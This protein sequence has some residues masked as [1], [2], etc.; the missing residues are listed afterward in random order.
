[1]VP[2]LAISQMR[3]I[4]TEAIGGDLDTGYSYM[5]K[6]GDALLQAARQMAPSPSGGDIAIVCGKG[7]N[8]G[9][10][11]VVARLLREAG[12]G[13]MCFSL[14]DPTDLKG[15][16][17]KAFD[18]YAQ[19]SGNYLVLDDAADCEGFA[20]YALVVDAVLG[21]GIKGE[22]HGLC[23]DVIA[24]MNRSDKPILAVDTPSG[25]DNDTGGVGESCVRARTTV[26]MGLPKL[27]A[28]QHPGRACVGT[29]VV[30]DL[31]YPDAIVNRHVQDV[32]VPTLDD[33]AALLPPRR[34]AGSKFD[35]GVTLLVSG[36]R[37]MAGSA[38]LASEAALRTGCGMVRCACPRSVADVLA[39]KV[40]ETVIV[41]LEET[42]SGSLSYQ[43]FDRIVEVAAKAQAVCIGP[44]LSHAP[45]TVRLV[46][47]L[48]A[49]LK[50]PMV[51]DA[52][53]LNAFKGR[54]ED[55]AR[56]KADTVITPH[57]GE[58]ER[59]FG[60]LPVKPQEIVGALKEKARELGL[61]ILLKGSP[62]M[63]AEP[64]GMVFVA[65]Y[66]TSALAKAG[67]GDVLS[68]IIVSLMAQGCSVVDAAILGAYLHG[69]AGERASRRLTEY[70][71][72]ARDVIGEV[73]RAIRGL[74]GSVRQQ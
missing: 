57:L 16:A 66:G 17:R 33:L 34:P 61:T 68:G 47:S 2:I 65:P 62:T 69:T 19:A 58:W 4:D 74:L 48:V 1:M 35:H 54:A 21:T 73:P 46:R 3:A 13:V 23:A 40:T 24:A 51:L 27:G 41:P 63:V 36:S 56:R 70:G 64:G 31:G 26:T 15:E 37:G 59:L 28:F 7:N 8:G 44:G 42:T 39:V 25:M 18:A 60:A 14:C 29:L 55:L 11:Y 50:A 22:P 12:Y 38:A 10:G 53:G 43:A 52:D 30:A 20:R 32:F 67:T 71:V 5:L 49:T 45:S 6:A 72:L 9:D